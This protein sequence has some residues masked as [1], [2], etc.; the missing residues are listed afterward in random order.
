MLKGKLYRWKQD[1]QRAE[2]FS[3]HALLL[4]RV[5]VGHFKFAKRRIYFKVQRK[6]K[7]LMSDLSM[8][9]VFT[10]LWGLN[11]LTRG[12]KSVFSI[13]GTFG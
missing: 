12:K 13:V 11:V 6:D 7:N 5:S 10:M 9:L 3:V 4:C 2:Q 1:K 8:C